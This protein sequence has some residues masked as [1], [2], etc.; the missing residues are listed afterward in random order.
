MYLEQTLRSAQMQKEERVDS[1]LAK[2]QETRGEFSAM[3][4]TP[5]DSELVRLALNSISDEWKV[6]VQSILGRV[7]LP[8]WDEMWAALNQEEL[9]GDLVKVKLE[10]SNNNGSNPTEEEDNATLASKGQQK[11]RRRKKD[12]LKIK[13]FRCGEMGHYATQCPLKKKEKD[14]KHDPKAMK[15]EEEFS[16]TAMI[17]LG[18]RWADMELQFE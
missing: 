8:N 16:M 6:F 7:A 12:V 10:G 5:Q 2:L 1:F 3:G 11:Q 4:H 14:E 13:C 15:I 17:L 9:R 18:G